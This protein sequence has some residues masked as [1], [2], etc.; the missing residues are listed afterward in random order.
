VTLYST[1]Q[2]TVTS[3][4]TLS[5]TT[6]ATSLLSTTS[7]ISTTVSTT[8]TSLTVKTTTA[9]TT[10][11]PG[12]VVLRRQVTV[13][14]SAIPTYAS[15]C[16]DAARYSSACSCWGIFATTVTAA[17]ATV[18]STVTVPASTTGTQTSISTV[19]TTVLTTETATTTGTELQSSTTT[20][21]A[22]STAT[23]LQA[24][25]RLNKAA[26]GSLL[27]YVARDLGP[28]ILPTITTD[29]L[30]AL[31]IKFPVSIGGPVTDLDFELVN[32][33]ATDAQGT[34]PTPWLGFY[35]AT[36]V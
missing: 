24:A 31:V 8:E 14:P 10:T 18:T 1:V 22:I 36:S 29:P 6:T 30:A 15:A 4:T 35:Y 33:Q 28:F 27:G 21:V 13:S 34:G 11:T 20:E 25:I 26:D 12:L 32:L 2:A 5:T 3:T 16:P 9:T 7:I 23:A 17:S 19:V